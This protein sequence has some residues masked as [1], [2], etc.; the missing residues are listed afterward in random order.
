MSK[1]MQAEAAVQLTL[2]PENVMPPVRNH[3]EKYLKS[4]QEEKEFAEDVKTRG[5]QVPIIVVGPFDDGRYQLVAGSRRHRAALLGKLS[6]I[7]AI[8]AGDKDTS[9]EEQDE[10]R[11]VENIQRRD[12]STAEQFT[13][14]AH[15]MER[16]LEKAPGNNQIEKEEHAIQA[17]ATVLGKSAVWV[18]HRWILGRLSEKARAAA[19]EGTLKMAYAIEIAKIA[20]HEKQDAMLGWVACDPPP[21]LDQVRRSVDQVALQLEEVPWR[22]DLA[23]GELP[24]C[25]TCPNNS[26]ARPDL[27]G[28]DKDDKPR[29]LR[30]VCYNAKSA[31]ARKA[32]RQVAKQA[33]TDKVKL[34]VDGLTPL[35]EG[36]IVTPEAVSRKLKDDKMRALPKPKEKEDGKSRAE[37]QAEEE[38]GRKVMQLVQTRTQEQGKR[39]C[40]LLNKEL[41]KVQGKGKSAG[42]IRL[43]MRLLISVGAGRRYYWQGL[44]PKARDARVKAMKAGIEGD[45]ATLAE[46]LEVS[47]LDQWECHSPEVISAWSEA[48]GVDVG[49]IKT[50]AQ[51]EKEARA[52]LKGADQEK[53]A[54]DP[55][56]PEGAKRQ[57]A[58]GRGKG[59]ERRR[60]ASRGGRAKARKR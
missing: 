38:L 10:M 57:P 35:T 58:S 47:K 3:R 24:A 1:D 26:G 56:K 22:K 25:D 13:A 2:D 32:V 41:E 53:A 5:V 15:I 7:P 42:L 59:K 39:I 49:E 20:D 52:E 14:V 4:D 34:T 30:P 27:F 44:K 29:C 6:G 31:M 33:K 12:L 8:V 19:H 48:L 51:L 23:I 37:R 18:R 46:G 45:L 16:K 36:A 60:T 54:E 50:E 11:A 43:A 28:A 55:P 17:T 9:E 40:G 21:A